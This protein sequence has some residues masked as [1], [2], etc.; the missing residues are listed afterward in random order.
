VSEPPLSVLFS[1]DGLEGTVG[2]DGGLGDHW[3]LVVVVGGRGEGVGPDGVAV[4]VHPLGRSGGRGGAA[5]R[6]PLGRRLAGVA[7]CGPVLSVGGG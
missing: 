6:C 1:G 3:R 2:G 4:A 5:L 7:V